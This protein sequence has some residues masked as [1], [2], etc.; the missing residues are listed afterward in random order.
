MSPLAPLP[1]GDLAAEGQPEDGAKK[2]KV[3][4]DK[5]VKRG[6]RTGTAGVPTPSSVGAPLWGATY[7]APPLNPVD[8]LDLGSLRASDFIGQQCEWSVDSRKY[9]TVARFVNHSC[10]PN[11]FVQSVLWDHHNMAVP[12][13]CMFAACNI[14]A[15]TELCYDYGYQ[16]D[17]VIGPDG[18]VAQKACHCGGKDCRGRM[19]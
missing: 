13:V 4:C 8:P 9:G 16:I 12:W 14:P 11:L 3:R 6:P 15:G 18:K 10:D 7:A 1:A 2:R 5:G 17:S 19:Y